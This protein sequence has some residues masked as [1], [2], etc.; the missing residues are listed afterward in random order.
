[1]REVVFS[2]HRI[3]QGAL[4]AH[5]DALKLSVSAASHEELHHEARDVLIRHFGAVHSTYRLRFDWPT[6]PINTALSAGKAL[7]RPA[8]QAEAPA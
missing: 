8:A 4:L 2:V 5:A 3:H 7:P 1:M 6:R